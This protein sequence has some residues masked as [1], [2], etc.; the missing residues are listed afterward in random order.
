MS[1]S[2]SADVTHP[3]A[4]IRPARPLWRRLP[5]R[6]F[7]V[8]LFAW[9]VVAL[10]VLGA[11]HLLLPQVDTYRTQIEAAVGEAL[12]RE[13][14]IDGIH[15]DWSGLHPHLA[16]R[17]VTL[18]DE[19]GQ[20]ALR[21]ELVDAALGFSSLVRGRMHLHRLD[22]NGPALQVRRD[23]AG[24]LHVAGLALRQDGTRGGFLPWLL[25]QGQINIRDAELEWHD[26]TRA[27]APPLKLTQ[28]NLRLDNSGDRH[29]FGLLATPPAELARQLELRGDVELPDIDQPAGASGEL[30]VSLDN[31]DLA[32]WQRWVDYPVDLPQGRGAVR[33]WANFDG[34][35]LNAVTGE[36]AL[37]DVKLRLLPD[38]PQLDLVS[39]S[40]RI[41]AEH[42]SRTRVSATARQLQ[43]L[44]R[45]GV[46][47]RPTS[48]DLN[49]QAAADGRA[50][51]GEISASVLDL[52]ALTRLSDFIPLP[53]PLRERLRD[54]APHGRLTDL[55]AGWTG[56]LSA[57]L[58]FRVSAGLD[59]I[60]F[61]ARG[62][63]PGVAGLS[64]K[65]EGSDARGSVVVDAPGLTFDLPAVFAE[66]QITFARFKLRA[67]WVRSDGETTVALESVVFQ[68]AD[69]EGEFTGRYRTLASTAGELDL[70]GRLQRSDA[71]AIWRYLPLTIGADTRDWLRDAL[72]AGGSPDATLKLRGK[73]DDFPFDRGQ[74]GVFLVK[75]KAEDVTVAFG[76]TWPAITGLDA[77]V[78]FEGKRMLI[79]SRDG[80]ILNTKL[81]TT[82]AEIPDLEAAEELLLV[83]GSA[84]G[85]TSEFLRYIDISP[86]AGRIDGFTRGMRAE[87]NG[88]LNVSLAI[89]L[90]HSQDAKIEGD[91]TFAGNR[92]VID[93]ALPPLT[94][95]A[96]RISFTE[97]ALT[98]RG[99]QATALGFPMTLDVASAGGGVVNVTASG[100]ASMEALRAQM[101]QPWLAALAGT[102]AWQARLGV[103]RNGMD[104]TLEADLAQL[105][106]TLPAP[107][108]KAAGEPMALRIERTGAL[109]ARESARRGLPVI[110]PD[111]E[112]LHIT[113]GELASADIVRR[114]TPTGW[115]IERGAIGLPQQPAMPERGLALSLRADTL[116]LDA[117]RRAFA[118]RPAPE[119][120]ADAAGSDDELPLSRVRLDA[121]H[122]RLM[123]HW[124]DAVKADA[125]RQAD[126]WEIDLASTQAR[127]RINWSGQG[128][129]RLQARFDHLL[130]NTAD[131]PGV[132]ALPDA[133]AEAADVLEDLP[134]LDIEAARFVLDGK[135]LGKLALQASNERRAWL[136][137]RLALELPEGSFDASGAWGKPLGAPGGVR[138]TRLDF[139]IRADDAGKLLDRL[140]HADALRRGTADMQGSLR[141]NGNPLS[142]D[143]PSLSGAFKLS[144][145][146]GQFSKI[147]P[148]AGRLLGILSLQALP[149]RITLDFRDV[150][151]EGFAFDLIEG[152]V[153]VERGIM[154]TD[155]FELAGPAARVRISG[156]ADIA[157]ETQNLVVRVQPALSDSVS[158]GVLIANPAVGVATYLAQK[159][160]RDPLGQIFAFQYGVTGS[161][162]DPVVAKLAV[163][164]AGKQ[165]EK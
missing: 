117:L 94:D 5:G 11:R 47:V 132:Q 41:S 109:D 95:A 51:Q 49:W 89:P 157:A 162:D 72:V 6:A 59:R 33:A 133:E 20:P 71:R 99:A 65:L 34:A 22:I 140:G 68:N 29:R 96:G 79:T 158:V 98:V 147:N 35:T 123:G 53:D 92:L 159:V 91:F 151:S 137:D 77:D 58:G 90:R 100:R 64:G 129:G 19:A 62:D 14:R 9:I 108:G 15:A 130:I 84:S 13:V 141:W 31:A 48:I 32:I 116:D 145:S 86:V 121:K 131:E 122:V 153:A 43:L 104:M 69:T 4:D 66:P 103:R 165:A 156:S 97:S 23:T 88:R 118:P 126:A 150:F 52:A 30:Y 164:P 107:L 142:I 134:A 76:G 120:A 106:S 154:K 56:E 114:A 60:G 128:K 80:R 36:V 149:R 75:V 93:D 115:V 102:A 152:N 12:E 46:R 10:V 3:S 124:L 27:G 26:E 63:V 73:L 74:P 16:L 44:T 55:D 39:L 24:V 111:R 18:L 83:R 119:V 17:G 45:D 125:Q 54:H 105:A 148:G 70:D 160:L 67:G 139:S 25:A 87:G 78:L 163:P 101:G 38:L 135:T 7:D 161:W 144:V 155:D 50:G 61:N 85:V 1:D 136:I 40:G 57:P 2:S 110:G 113:L 8:L 112:L 42:L 28:V 81:G 37:S 21:L 138:E 127:G 146:K 82:T 143:Y